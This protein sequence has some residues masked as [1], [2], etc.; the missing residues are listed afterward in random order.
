MTPSVRVLFL[1]DTARNGGP[2]GACTTFFAFSTP[3]SF[4]GPSSC[5]V[6]TRSPSVPRVLA[7]PCQ[8]QRLDGSTPRERGGFGH[9]LENRTQ[10]I[11][12]TG[13]VS[14]GFIKSM[15]N[16]IEELVS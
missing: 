11:D 15:R 9:S 8:A 1:N 2:A 7:W 13:H 10:R 3:L 6:P 14:G 4:I 5:R 16:G 12:V